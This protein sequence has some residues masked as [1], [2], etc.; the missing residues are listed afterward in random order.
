MKQCP[1]C[2][3]EVREN[4]QFCPKCGASLDATQHVLYHPVRANRATGVLA[5]V[6]SVLGGIIGFFFS[7][8]GLMDPRSS[9]VTKNQCIAGLAICTLW[10]IIYI[11]AAITM[12]VLLAVGMI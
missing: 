5:L 7:M 3:N 4:D 12:T 11:A 2:K 1:F 9:V 6:F 8:V 10:G